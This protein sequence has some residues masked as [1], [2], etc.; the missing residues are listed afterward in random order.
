MKPIQHKQD[1]LFPWTVLNAVVVVISYHHIAQRVGKEM[2]HQSSQ[3]TLLGDPAIEPA[4]NW[5]RNH[6]TQAQ[7]LGEWSKRYADEKER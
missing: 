4:I 2:S 3:L 7:S 5:N 1:I 6:A